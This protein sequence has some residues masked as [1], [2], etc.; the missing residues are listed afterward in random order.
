MQNPIGLIQHLCTVCNGAH[1]F[2]S[3]RGL[4]KQASRRASLVVHP[5]QDRTKRPYFRGDGCMS[6]TSLN[7]IGIGLSRKVRNADDVADRDSK[8]ILLVTSI[9]EGT[10]VNGSTGET[11]KAE[12]ESMRRQWKIADL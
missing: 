11:M 12:D 5:P 6:P 7:T 10:L 9:N 2:Y 3:S 4:V 8:D 1:K